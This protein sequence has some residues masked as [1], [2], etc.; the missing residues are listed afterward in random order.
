MAILK[1]MSGEIEIRLR[2]PPFDTIEPVYFD[3]YASCTVRETPWDGERT[4]YVVPEDTAYAMEIIVKKGYR[5][6]KKWTGF[7]IR[8]EDL[9]TNRQ[10]YNRLPEKACEKDVLITDQVILI[11]TVDSAV[12]N[13]ELRFGPELTF[14]AM[15]PGKFIPCKQ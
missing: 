2:K 7:A 15:S 14:Q 4:R 13:G 10:I 1:R 8:V 5:F 9:A 6:S 3:E 11:D 12:V